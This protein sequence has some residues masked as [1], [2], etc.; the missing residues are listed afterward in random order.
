MT[1][2]THPSTVMVTGATGFTGGALARE[3]VRQGRHVRALVRDPQKA[4]ALSEAGMEPIE[5][6]IRDA[7]AVRRAAEG[8]EVIYHIA[9]VFRTAGHPDSYYTDINE[10]GVV[11]VIDAAKALGTPRTVHCSTVGVHGHVSEIPSNEDS[12]Y[13]PGD[14]YQ[15]TKLEGEKRMQEAIAEGF[16]GVIFRPAGMYGP[17][18]LR[19]LKVFKGIQKGRFPMFGSG[20]ITY[21]F[22]YIDDLVDG[23]ILCGEHPDAMGGLFILCAD[24]WITLNEFFRLVADAVGGR[25]PRIHWPVSPLLLAAKTCEVLCKPLG[26]DPPLHTRRCEFYIKAR[27]FS[28]AKAKQALGYQ[29]KIDMAEGI[30]RT[31][32]WYAEQGLIAPVPELAAASAAA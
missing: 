2:Q 3:L 18:D 30:R 19:F 21:Q 27:A 24:G 14:V 15:V 22:T 11:N 1:S 7:D 10:G 5:G 13:N 31:A 20:E 26:I 8:A 23:I 9:A 12:P 16:P 6:D 29:P 25:P 17:G 32:R 28:N 4:N